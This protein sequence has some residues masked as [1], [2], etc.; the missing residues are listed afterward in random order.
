M[1]LLERA[2]AELIRRATSVWFDRR[3]ELAFEDYP[4]YFSGLGEV[5]SF[6]EKTES[7]SEL[8]AKI[9]KGEFESIGY[10]IDDNYCL[11]EFLQDLRK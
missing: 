3:G 8:I 10:F 5:I 2:K 9:E 6:I 1:K 7:F 4:S 11:E